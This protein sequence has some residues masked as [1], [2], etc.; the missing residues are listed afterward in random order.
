MSYDI[1]L[2]DPVTRKV[3]QLA[4]RHQMRGG[5]YTVGGTKDCSLNVTY[6]YAPQFIRVFEPLEKPHANAP[7]WMSERDKT[8]PVRGIRTIY[9]LTGT[10]SLPVLDAA[11]ANLGDDMHPDY[12][13][14]TDGNAK[15]VLHQL[16]ALAVL[17]PDGI[18]AGA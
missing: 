1:E 8:Q 4:E 7:E 3:L 9:G 14:A 15:V 18:W 6:N 5:T 17:R 12:W 16:R 13:K 11:I 10:E 2:V